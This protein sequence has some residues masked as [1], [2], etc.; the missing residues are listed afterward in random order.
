[1]KNQYSMTKWISATLLSLCLASCDPL[2]IEPTTMVDETRFWEN[3]Q[4]SRSYV[5]NFYTWAPAT[6]GDSFQSEQWSDNCIGW[7]DT[8]RNT[9]RQTAFTHRQ[10]DPVTSID[11]FSAPWGGQYKKIR[12]VNLGL[13]RIG[14]SSVILENDKSQMLGEC[15]FFRAWLYFE[16]EQYWGPVPYVDRTLTV[17]DETMI[18]R[19]PREE[20]FDNILAD[21]DK[22][23]E[24]FKATKNNPQ[25]G[26][27]NIHAVY[28]FKSRVAL[29]AACAAEAS[30]KGLFNF[31]D[32]GNLF[33]FSKSAAS[34]YQIALD[35]ANEVIGKYSLEPN[36]EDLFTTD[37]SYNSVESI[38]PM[39]F[40][41]NQR[42]GFNPTG[43]NGPEGQYYGNTAEASYSWGLEGG[44]FPTQDLVDCYYQK[45]AADGKWKQW[46]K[47]K[48]A[49]VDM[50]GTVDANGNY[51]GS[52][53]DYRKLM[54]GDRDKRFYSTVTYDGSFMGPE[55]NIRYIIQTW[56]DDSNIQEG[57]NL[58]Y[59]SLHT[60]YAGTPRFQIP[61]GR[62]MTITGYYS[63]K[64]SHFDMFNDNGTLNTVQ[65]TTCYFMLRYA[66]VLLN[67]AEAAIK[68]GQEGN[69]LPKI[70]EIRRRAGLDDFDAS[71]AGH[72]L[73]EEY[74]LQ[75]RIEFA[76]EVPGQRYYDLLRWGESEGKTVIEEL[77]RAPK[78][79]RIF[80]KGIESNKYGEQGY[81]VEPDGEGY[82]V[83]R[84]QTLRYDTYPNNYSEYTKKFDHARYY[85]I[86][87]PETM[88]TS[89]R[90]LIQ[91][92]GWTNFNYK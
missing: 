72:N 31:D 49:L 36:Y 83:P 50:K 30:A 77:N 92:P 11:G 39:M 16:L 60:G 35:A 82:F 53:A 18:P 64:Y 46:W 32:S 88:I 42:G 38:W 61:V 43:H 65:R 87:F 68:L 71:V 76:F 8:Q 78:A 22:A 10:Y 24:M 29:Y 17:N 20:L 4:L 79:V 14:S 73:W 2:G 13:E 59:S 56:I 6:A 75:R 90:G 19:C 70:N 40:K 9:Y 89:Y 1:M 34:Y 3:A 58:Q 80:R 51:S 66:E 37:D 47:T 52:S 25:A 15:Y 84:I 48:Q 44:T 69:A 63:R 12:S 54:Y 62:T 81:P 41:E 45:D 23:I 26:M 74:K 91:N 57:K 28:T 55:D 85:F 27:I 33:S 67:Y 86:P 7:L 5:N 21:L